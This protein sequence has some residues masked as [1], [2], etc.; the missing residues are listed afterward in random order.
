MPRA[1]ARAT[2]D[3]IALHH[4]DDASIAART[5]REQMPVILPDYTPP[6]DAGAALA[7][8]GVMPPF[9]LVSLPVT[10]DGL[11]F[12]VVQA[13]N[14]SP[15]YVGADAPE[16][17]EEIGVLFGAALASARRRNELTTLGKTIAQVNASLDLTTTLDAI[18]QGLMALVPCVLSAIYLDGL[19][20]D[21]LVPMAMRTE[22]E[23]E[24]YAT[25]HPRPIDGSLTGWVYRHRQAVNVPDLHNDPRVIR[26]GPDALH[27]DSDTR[28]SLMVPLMAGND[29]V[30]TLIASRRGTHAF[31]DDDLRDVERFAPLAAQA[32]VNARLYAEAESGRERSEQLLD[33]MADAIIRLDRNSIVVGWNTGAE[34]LFGYTAA[35]VLGNFPPLV[36]L[37]DQSETAGMWE[38]VLNQRREFHAD[39]EQAAP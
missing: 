35:E 12:G 4:L 34:R 16:A 29:P 38:R 17:L 30:G 21:A 39:R 26:H 10:A 25:T 19:V 28:S 31:S 18:L 1:V 8:I 13:I 5:L 23:G 37:D 32:V 6:P 3:A 2:R 33:D 27:P 14:V 36:P 15:R 11:R 22:G 9:N 20:P 7:A 24:R